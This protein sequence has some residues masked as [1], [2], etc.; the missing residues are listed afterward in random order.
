[1]QRLTLVYYMKIH[2]NPCGVVGARTGYPRTPNVSLDTRVLPVR[3]YQGLHTNSWTSCLS[4]IFNVIHQWIFLNELY[5]LMKMF[6]KF[7]LAE[8]RKIFKPREY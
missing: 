4:Q 8:N 5:K 3:L 1:M 6:F 7:Q 2:L